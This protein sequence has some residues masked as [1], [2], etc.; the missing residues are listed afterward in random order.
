M[1]ASASSETPH[2]STGGLNTTSFS[3]RNQHLLPHSP[4]GGGTGQVLPPLPHFPHS[5]VAK[6]ASF[7]QLQ[8]SAFS[9]KSQFFVPNMEPPTPAASTPSPL[10]QVG[11]GANP[12]NAI[13][14][15]SEF[16]QLSVE[17]GSLF[18]GQADIKCLQ[19][20]KLINSHRAAEGGVFDPATIKLLAQAYRIDGG[21]NSCAFNY[22]VAKD[23]GLE[24]RAA[25]WSTANALLAFPASP[26]AHAAATTSTGEIAAET[27]SKTMISFAVPLLG[28]LMLDLVNL[29]DCQH[30]VVLCEILA[31]Y[32]S[33]LLRESLESANISQLRKREAYHCYISL[34]QKLRLFASANSI[35]KQQIRTETG[36]IF[37]QEATIMHLSC[38]KCGKELPEH[39]N[40][41]HNPQVAAATSLLPYCQKCNQSVGLCVLCQRPVQGLFLWCQVC[42][43]GGHRPC[44]RLW[45]EREASCASGCGHSCT[46]QL[47]SA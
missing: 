46:F 15:S 44:L 21:Q 32:N 28:Q 10:L 17:S 45:F 18:V 24:C 42:G 14:L 33:Q 40:I 30:F 22:Q 34:L 26:P 35:I 3:S 5:S 1:H 47:H 4:Q 37:T 6:M 19:A 8:L 16:T 12:M 9:P 29:G 27:S 38:A 36:N 23:A 31:Q 13:S 11:A 20:A 2:C 41:H 7:Q 25:I 43:H 39:Q